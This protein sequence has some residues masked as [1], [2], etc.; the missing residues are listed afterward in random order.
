M[1]F[2]IEIALRAAFSRSPAN[3]VNCQWKSC[4]EA[5]N[6]RVTVHAHIKNLKTGEEREIIMK[7]DSP[8][9]KPTALGSFKNVDPEIGRMTAGFWK[10]V[11]GN[12][13]AAIDLKTKYLLSLANAVGGKR[14]RQASRELIKAYAA[15]TTVLEFDELFTLFIWNQGMGHFASEVA[16]SPLFAIY[17]FIKSEE[18]N[19]HTRN[20]IVDRI[21]D[22]FGEGNPEVSAL[23]K[24]FKGQ[25]P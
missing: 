18:A 23:P 8:P 19:G 24:S 21:L 10:K 4:L 12:E 3:L 17:Q 1:L 11:W 2:F 5:G 22:R 25:T 13:N 14:Y 9:L 20:E 15:G 16:S 6:V 7:E